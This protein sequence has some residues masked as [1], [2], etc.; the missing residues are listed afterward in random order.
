MARLTPIRKADTIKKVPVSG[1][2]KSEG[3]KV[4]W[5]GRGTGG[6]G[7]GGMTGGLRRGERGVVMAGQG[8]PEGPGGWT[9]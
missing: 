5:L 9:Q 6:D 3:L 1:G 4:V 2:R 8:S 7:T